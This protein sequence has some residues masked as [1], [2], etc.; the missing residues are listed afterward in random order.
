MYATSNC[1]QCLLV[2]NQRYR[3]P[4]GQSKLDNPDKT[5]EKQSK[6][7]TQYLLDTTKRKHMQIT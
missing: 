3:I 6:I 4:K 5:Q 2:V 1:C 7:T